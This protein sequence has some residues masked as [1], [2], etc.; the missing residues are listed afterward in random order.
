MTYTLVSLRFFAVIFLYNALLLGQ[1]LSE[2]L[3]V[4]GH[5]YDGQSGE[6]LIGANLYDPSKAKA[7][8]TNAYGF[9]H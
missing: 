7:T 6:V 9:F 3:I 1:N 2:E 8:T 4:S 5:V